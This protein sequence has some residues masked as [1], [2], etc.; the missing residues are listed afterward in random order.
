M[1]R[2][3]TAAEPSGGSGCPHV[4]TWYCSR[5]QRWVRLPSCTDMVLQQSP[6]V[7]PAALM[8]RH[9]TAAEPS[10]GSG[11]PQQS[12]AV[13]RH[14][15]AAEPSGGSGCPHVQTWY[16]SRAQRWVRLPSCT[17]M[18]LQQSPA[19]GPAALMYRHGTAAEPSGGS[20]CPHA[21]TWYC[22]RAQRWVRLPSCTDMVLQQSPA[23]GP[24]ALTW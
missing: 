18:V 24:A 1:Y 11:C 2:H 22:S 19:V 6:A 3:G 7:G 13:R 15:T 16:C 20:G 9:G 17:D 10:G 23:V 21:Q 4:Q 8:H 12:P 5:A 14:G